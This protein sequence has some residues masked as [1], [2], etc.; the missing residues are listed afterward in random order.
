MLVFVPKVHEE[1]R[2]VPSDRDD[3]T[4]S[5]PSFRS[6]FKGFHRSSSSVAL[7]CTN[8]HDLFSIMRV[9]EE[10]LLKEPLSKLE[11]V[12]GQIIAP[13]N[14]FSI[15]YPPGMNPEQMKENFQVK[16]ATLPG[17]IA[18]LTNPD[19]V[20]VEFRS[21]F[22]LTYRIFS[23]CEEIL[24]LLGQRY[25]ESTSQQT[26]LSPVQ[27]RVLGAVK[28]WLQA[29]WASDFASSPQNIE[30]LKNTVSQWGDKRNEIGRIIEE[31]SQARQI[32]RTPTNFPES[33]PPTTK[34]NPQFITIG[35]IP[36]TEV[37]RQIAINSFKVY[38]KILPLEFFNL[39]WSRRE[40]ADQCPNLLKMIEKFNILSNWTAQNIV[41]PV[42]LQ[43]R[44]AN[45]IWF[46]QLSEELMKL[47]DIHSTVAVHRGIHV[48][49]VK[50]L[51]RTWK[52]LPE[53]WATRMQIVKNL[54]QE[55]GD[56]E[57]LRFRIQNSGTPVVPYVGLYLR[58]LV[59]IEENYPTYSENG[60]IH[61]TKCR[62]IGQL[63]G[64]LQV[65]QKS[66][67]DC[68]FETLPE[69]Q[70]WIDNLQLMPAS[71]LKA[72][73]LLVEPPNPSWEC[74]EEL[75]HSYDLNNNIEIPPSSRTIE[76]EK[77]S[78][79]TPEE[80]EPETNP[81]N[82][83]NSVAVRFAKRSKHKNASLECLSP[84]GEQSE[85][86]EKAIPVAR[87]LSNSTESITNLNQSGGED[88]GEKT[89]KKKSK[90][91]LFKKKHSKN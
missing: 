87:S 57:M 31:L 18:Y 65:Y 50:R 90:S 30:L 24:T 22:F 38:S 3:D 89:R 66:G 44:L 15:Q 37:A 75:L 33:F 77:E 63:I 35:S 69:V 76:K 64:E 91:V 84:R 78:S 13:T 82:P 8:T 79:P 2:R 74:Y 73:S 59:K 29:H 6:R 62:K 12:K 48:P 70:D 1:Q 10:M 26:A 68:L 17:L 52:A 32:P 56:F 25:L 61:F 72:R 81:E 41:Y 46:T 47:N 86:S 11:T 58:D 51:T 20:A 14:N 88:K 34:L 9:S 40:K 5:S 83:E 49:E 55:R 60:L 80:S 39:G 53:S 36:V 21:E 42:K 43:D 19:C 54:T 45:L 4:K 28:A 67:H 7:S 85:G 23:T 27:V 71:E 16:Y